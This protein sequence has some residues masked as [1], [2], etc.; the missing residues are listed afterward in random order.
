MKKAPGEAAMVLIAAILGS[1]MSF[2]DSTAVNVS[3]PY[4]SASF[5]PQTARRSG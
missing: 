4:F 1:A 5:T 2:I 3:L